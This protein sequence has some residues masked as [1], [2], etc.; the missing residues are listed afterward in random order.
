MKKQNKCI[1][2]GKPLPYRWK[3][4]NMGS[5][6]DVAFNDYLGWDTWVFTEFE[7]EAHPHWHETNID[8]SHRS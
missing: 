3:K 4:C 7:P 2:C 1:L 5:A 8:A 6:C